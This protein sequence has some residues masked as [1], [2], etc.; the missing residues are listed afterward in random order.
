MGLVQRPGARHS[1]QDVE[2]EMGLCVTG[3]ELRQ[4]KS[5]G[6]VLGS[7]VVRLVVL[8][9]HQ[10]VSVHTGPVSLFDH[11]LAQGLWLQAL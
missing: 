1:E 6:Q 9:R 5:L 8:D 7:A 2:I 10:T 3:L 4:S 11:W